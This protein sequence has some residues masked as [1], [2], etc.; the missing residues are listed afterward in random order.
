M[1]TT[2]AVARATKR[3][4]VSSP[5]PLRT[6]FNQMSCAN[7]DDAVMV[8]PATT[9]RIVAKATAATNAMS[10]DPPRLPAS[11]GAAKLL[12]GSGTT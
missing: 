11:S 8:S 10:S 9:A 5:W 12:S 6:K 2:S 1:P 3:C 4:S 7:A